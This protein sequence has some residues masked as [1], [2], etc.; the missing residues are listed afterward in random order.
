MAFDAGGVFTRLYSWET[1]RDNGVKVN[2]TRM[3]AEFDGV[4]AALSLCFLRD[5]RA[6][7]TDDF[8]LGGFKIQNL[9]DAGAN[10]DAVS[11]SF[12]DARYQGIDAQLS[13]MAALTP[14]ANQFMYWSAA[15]V[16]AMGSFGTGLSFSGGTLDLNTTI[17]TAR[18]FTSILTGDLSSGAYPGTAPSSTSFHAMTSNGGIAKYLVTSFGIQTQYAGRRADNTRESPAALASSDVVLQLCAQGWD[19][20]NWS[21]NQAAINLAASEAW[22]STAKGTFISFLTTADGTTTQ[23]ETA[24]FDYDT[25]FSMYGAVSTPVID[26]SRHFRP[27]S[28]TIAGL[29]AGAAANEIAQVSD[30]GG[31]AGPVCMSGAAGSWRRM[32]IDGYQTKGDASLTLKALTDAVY[33]NAAT[34]LTANRTYTLSNTEAYAGAPKIIRRSAGGAFTLTIANNGGTA[35]FVFPASS[36]G[37][38][39]FVHDGTDW[40]LVAAHASGTYTPTLTNTTNVAASTAASCQFSVVGTTVT[41]SGTVQIDPTS[42]SVATLMGMSLPLAS[43]LANAN[44][45]AGVAF[46][47]AVF[48]YGAAIEGDATNDRASF[49]FIADA[50]AANQTFSFSFTYRVI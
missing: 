17:P 24:R 43:N 46:C 31:G 27:R 32:G 39:E 29:P 4:A 30:L 3:D 7:A 25:G 37:F 11:R 47:G 8:D 2:A 33:I 26:A 16:A 49:K 12:G 41:V 40:Q 1:D 38:A 6:P 45:L 22:S 48:G 34:T 23:S 14:A 21:S 10:G 35:L 13:A 36:T 44:E 5:G 50:G 42:A 20:T 9:A 15:T 28:Y 19:G 18:T